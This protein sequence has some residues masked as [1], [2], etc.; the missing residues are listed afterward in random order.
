MKRFCTDHEIWIEQE[1]QK[2][3]AT[4]RLLAI[5]L[6][7]LH[8]LQHERLIHLLVLIMTLFTE[9]FFVFL[10]LT[11]PEI[12]LASAAVMLI[13]IVLLL[14]YFIHY[15]F[16]ENTTQHWYRIA[17]KIMEKIEQ[18]DKKEGNELSSAFLCG[19]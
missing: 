9:L 18:N 17:E 10:A 4:E 12:K 2:S 8:W 14:F 6:E 7:K 5:H 13:L 16:L 3:G 19:E 1:I 15:F 11:Y